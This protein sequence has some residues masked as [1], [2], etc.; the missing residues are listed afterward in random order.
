MMSN[1]RRNAFSVLEVRNFDE[2]LFYCF[3]I[4]QNC[5]CSLF[6]SLLFFLLLNFAKCKNIVYACIRGF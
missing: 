4:F 2:N 3:D 6:A 1:K 5:N